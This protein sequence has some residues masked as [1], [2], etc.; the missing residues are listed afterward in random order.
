VECKREF[1]LSEEI[2]LIRNSGE[3]PEVAFHGSLYFLTRDPDGPG[4]RLTAEDLALLEDQVVVRY[5][6][7]IHRDLTPENRERRIY[8]GLARAA[9]N[10]QR[11]LKFC[12]K[13]ARDP[14]WHRRET[15]KALQNFLVR[16][17]EEV[18]K[19]GRSSA[20]NCTVGALMDFASE[21]GL[22]PEEKPRGWQDLCRTDG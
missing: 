9:V 1:L 10:W 21:L 6:E 2:V 13:T 12:R 11:L 16:E 5:L 17:V 22:A 4:I 8:R 18:K 3:I 7:I 15:A 14:D 19:S 20:V